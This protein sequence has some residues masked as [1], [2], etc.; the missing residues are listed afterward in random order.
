[1]IFSVYLQVVTIHSRS[2]LHTQI[3]PAKQKEVPMV[4]PDSI[5]EFTKDRSYT[6]DEVGMSGARILR[7]EDMV[8][9]IQSSGEESEHEVQMMS[10]MKGRLPVPDI[11]C[12]EKKDDMS[13][14]LMS[15]VPGEMACS[16][17]YY[18]E[19]EE[20]VRLLAE[21]LNMLW[22]VDIRECPFINN[23]QN[24]LRLAE[25]Q[26]RDGL[27]DM[28]NIE[29]ETYGE[30]GFEGPEQLLEWL[31]MH[32]PEEELVFSHGDFCLPNVFFD[33]GTVSGF[34]DLGNCGIADKYQDVALCYRSLKH[35]LNGKYGRNV[36]TDIKAEQL[37]EE[38]ELEPDWEKIR[39][40]NL[41]DELF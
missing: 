19:P 1:M 8:L 35:N 26:V 31:F 33:G 20:L 6:L 3:Q 25:K 41:M 12:H 15:C 11:L 16:D 22:Q 9:K 28:E 30:G 13:Y 7:F 38:L 40:F 10:W 29:P 36:L 37:F 18:R 24:K 5:K 4:I 32:Q 14:L 39:Y 17:K 27:C 21:G 2:T 34:I 23:T